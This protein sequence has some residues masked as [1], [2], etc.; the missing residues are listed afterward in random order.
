MY[1][2]NS[3]L[4]SRSGYDAAQLEAAERSLSPGNGYQNFQM[5]ID[6]ENNYG[7]NAL[8]VLAHADIESAHATSY[9][10]RARN[11]L[12]GFNAIDSDPNQASTYADQ[13][14]SVDFYGSFLKKYYLTPGAV[15]Y[16]GDTPHGVFVKYSSSHD[17]EAQN[18]VGLMNQ[19]EAHVSGTSPAPTPT[20]DGSGT[21]YIVQSGDTLWGIAN[22][23]GL[24][25]ARLEQLN[26]QI[27]NPNLIYPGQAVHVSGAPAQT[28]YTV[29]SGD[30]LSGIAAQ[31]G[32]TYQQLA[33]I[34]G[35]ANPDLIYPGQQIKIG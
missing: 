14:A 6:C 5:F 15:Y 24:S 4:L 17:S 32:T 22:A 31:F 30:T 1:D 8:F 21:D 3:N 2:I 12:F 7:I 26:P 19:L 23:H 18:V 11:N 35:I 16:N 27:A 29:V 10:A 13:A 28:I 9:Y 25:L 20:P 33:A 34:N